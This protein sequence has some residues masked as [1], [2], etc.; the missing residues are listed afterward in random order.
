LKPWSREW[1]FDGNDP[2][3]QAQSEH[4]K[5]LFGPSAEEEAQANLKALSAAISGA[6]GALAPLTK[7]QAAGTR[8]NAGAGTANAVNPAAAAK[9]GQQAGVAAGV[10]LERVPAFG[11]SPDASSVLQQKGAL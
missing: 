11:Q 4:S 8:G 6:Q 1:V 7:G 9:A 10:G 5:P 3:S 2:I